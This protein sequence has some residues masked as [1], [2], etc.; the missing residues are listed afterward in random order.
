MRIKIAII[1]CVLVVNL[2]VLTIGYG[3]S[4]VNV[5]A[6]V[7]LT[8]N[9]KKDTISPSPNPSFKENKFQY[10][11]EKYWEAGQTKEEY[12]I[13]QNYS[14]YDKI[15]TLGLMIVLMFITALFTLIIL[16]TIEYYKLCAKKR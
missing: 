4:N 15:T 6:V 3:Q 10:Y 16:R 2:L 1:I 14:F 5:Q 9:N 8:E 13:E 12:N 11:F 7:P